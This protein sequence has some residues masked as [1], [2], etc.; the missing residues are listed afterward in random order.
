[1]ETYVRQPDD[2][3]TTALDPAAVEHELRMVHEAI[4][5]VASGAAPRVIIANIKFGSVVLDAARRIALSRGLRVRPLWR[6]D[7]E[8]DLAV[9]PITP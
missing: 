7:M 1:V 2:A 3:R 9:E 5:L 4:A 6:A 8:A